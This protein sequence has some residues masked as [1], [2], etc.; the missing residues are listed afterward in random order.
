V[1]EV[2][3]SFSARVDFRLVLPVVYHMICTGLLTTDFI[4]PINEQSI[5]SIGSSS[6]QILE[7][8]EIR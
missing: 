4:K 7:F 5:V 3:R 2:A 6:T 1:N 8:F